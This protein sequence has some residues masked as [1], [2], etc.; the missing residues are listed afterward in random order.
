LAAGRWRGHGQTGVQKNIQLA[1]SWAN[2]NVAAQ[3]EFLAL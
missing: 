3:R 1:G 2:L